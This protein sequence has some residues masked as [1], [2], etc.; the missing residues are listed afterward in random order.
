MRKHE[1]VELNVPLLH[2]PSRWTANQKSYV[3]ERAGQKYFIFLARKESDRTQN[4]TFYRTG[5]KRLTFVYFNL[6]IQQLVLYAAIK[7]YKK[8]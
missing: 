2:T 1:N 8:D 6:K 4:A 7:A 5:K 3:A